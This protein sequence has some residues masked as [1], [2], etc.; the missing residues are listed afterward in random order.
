MTVPSGQPAADGPRGHLSRDAGASPVEMAILWPA[1]VLALFGA[2]QVSM[3]FS[4]RSV[5]LT[6]AQAAVAAERQLDAQPGS[7]K[8]RAQ[9]LLA[10][11]GD[12]LADPATGH[13]VAGPVHT[14]T[15]VSY[16]VR[17]RAI[18]LIPGVTWEISQTAHG[19]REELTRSPARS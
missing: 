1:L 13:Q 11:S 2:I 10:A 12:W 3:Y 14:G 19:T 4:A 9:Q 15:G 7:G 16:T 18:S 8:L 6:A 5:A 17:G